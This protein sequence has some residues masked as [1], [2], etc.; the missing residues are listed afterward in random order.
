M[1]KSVKDALPFLEK[2]VNGGMY[3]NIGEA[4]KEFKIMRERRVGTSKSIRG[5]RNG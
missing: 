5:A 1:G 2:L 3:S 4:V